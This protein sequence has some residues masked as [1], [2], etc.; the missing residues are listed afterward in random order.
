M[1]QYERVYREYFGE[2]DV[3]LF[4]VSVKAYLETYI[5]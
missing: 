4:T 3:N 5:I 2:S 1:G